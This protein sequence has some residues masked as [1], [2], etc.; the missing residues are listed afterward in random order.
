M[1]IPTPLPGTHSVPII[2]RPNRSR[3]RCPVRRAERWNRLRVANLPDQDAS[4][5][6][7]QDGIRETAACHQRCAD[8]VERQ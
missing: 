6:G 2:S 4:C 8:A 3:R 7:I 1:Y 5:D